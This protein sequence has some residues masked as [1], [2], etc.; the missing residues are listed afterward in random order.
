MQRNSYCSLN[1]P[2]FFGSHLKH[3]MVENSP[4][5]LRKR[6]LKSK[7]LAARMASRPNIANMLDRKLVVRWRHLSAGFVQLHRNLLGS[8]C[9]RTTSTVSALLRHVD[10]F[11]VRGGRHPP[12]I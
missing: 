9:S 10:Y 12:A 4:T 7:N 11:R 5:L 6:R 2:S 3:W 8:G 1:G